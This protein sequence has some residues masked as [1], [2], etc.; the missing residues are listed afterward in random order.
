M[1]QMAPESY[2]LFLKRIKE[3]IVSSQL[4]TALSV[5]RELVELYWRL[6]VALLAK[7]QREHW[8]GKTLEQ[9][10]QDLQEAF[11]ARNGFSTANLRYMIQF[12]SHYPNELEL[13]QLAQLPW[14]HHIALLQ[15]MPRP[16]EALWYAN[17]A[18]EQGWSRSSLIHSIKSELHRR[19]QA[20]LLTPKGTLSTSLLQS[21]LAAEM[22]KD[23][24]K[25]D[26]LPIDDH[27]EEQTTHAEW[28]FQLQ[29]FFLRL[30]RGFALVGSHYLLST[31]QE[32]H[33]I[34][35]LFYQL[36]LRSYLLIQ[37]HLDGAHQAIGQL[38]RCRSAV[39]ALLCRKEDQPTIGLL[40]H[41]RKGELQIEH[42][43]DDQEAIAELSL[44]AS[45]LIAFLCD[46]FS[47]VYLL[48]LRACPPSPSHASCF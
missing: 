43:L 38:H 34:D 20:A 37:L 23:G 4:K 24:Y 41:K 13:Q 30:D 33:S 44:Y 1:D 14:N 45:R 2:R 35:L 42:A 36:R 16:E 31:E 39:D 26:L 40:L 29:Q 3:Q 5:N 7:Q 9:L 21:P 46:Q 22:I 25:L 8:D 48:Q 27:L 18:I 17:K 12:A 15:L 10:S 11:P 6:G 19:H 47:D 32:C 28:L